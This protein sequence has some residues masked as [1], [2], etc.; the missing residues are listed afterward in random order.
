[1]TFDTFVINKPCPICSS[2]VAFCKSTAFSNQWNLYKLG[3]TLP[4][5]TKK[6]T[7][8]LINCDHCN[9]YRTDWRIC[10]KVVN[11]IYSGSEIIQL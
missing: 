8:E 3:D 7:C 1:M 5:K 6:N 2:N 4:P 9:V 10:I 11:N